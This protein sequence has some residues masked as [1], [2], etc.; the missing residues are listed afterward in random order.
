MN[1]PYQHQVLPIGHI[2]FIHLIG[3]GVNS[4]LRCEILT[5][6]FDE[7]P[8]DKALCYV[9]GDRSTTDELSCT[10]GFLRITK[11]LRMALHEL[12]SA[13]DQLFWIEQLCI[14]QSNKA[15]QSYQVNLMGR[16]FSRAQQVIMW[17][18]PDREN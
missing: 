2:R 15:E 17:L 4:S 14:D 16:I 6:P 10:D 1:T 7:A 5:V 8:A 12:S 11:N 3:S 18:G 13:E 9:W